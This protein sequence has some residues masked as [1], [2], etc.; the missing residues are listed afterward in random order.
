MR[1]ST[2]QLHGDPTAT[3]EESSVSTLARFDDSATHLSEF[4]DAWMSDAHGARAAQQRPT[5][6]RLRGRHD[7][8]CGHHVEDVLGIED[9]GDLPVGDGELGAAEL[10]VQAVEIDQLLV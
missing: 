6:A 9:P 3:G 5:R 10:G 2:C 4:V 8:A 1:A 7:V